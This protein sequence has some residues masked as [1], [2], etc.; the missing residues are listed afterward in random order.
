MNTE[1]AEPPTPTRKLWARILASKFLVVSIAVHLLFGV[2]ATLYVVQRYSA[3]RKLTFQGGP[4]TT[5]P[6]KRALEHKVSMAKKKNSM[7]APAQAKRITTSGLAKI[8]LPEMPAMP[9]ATTVTANRMGG[10]G[11]FG[12]GVGPPGGMGR[13]GGGGVGGGGL[14]MF[15][16]R[17][18]GAGLVGTFYDLKQTQDGK[19]TDVAPVPGENVDVG[20]PQAK[21]YVEIV[22]RFVT[23]GWNVGSLGKYFKAPNK[24]VATQFMLPNMSALEAPK[25]FQVEKEVQARRWLVHYEGS[26][27]PP[28]AGR[29]RFIGCADDIMVVRCKG[30]NVLD[31]CIDFYRVDPKI[32]GEDNV[33]PGIIGPTPMRASHWIEMREGESVKMEVL[34]GENPGG[35]FSGALMVERDGDAH[36]PGVFPVFQLK[37]M[38]IPPGRLPRTEGSI[39]FTA[40]APGTGSALDAL[41][42]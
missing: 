19:P 2:G 5:N 33:G 15:G 10:M 42:H 25:A 34:I 14:T 30:R 38:D 4:P 39:I 18:Q 6:S 29:Y 1:S 17:G 37:K 9:T 7:S 8:V 3:Q 21:K 31:A 20:S 41:R 23:N 22:K 11:G 28:N 24:L 27:T 40:A 35:E 32:N 26:I 16:F 36:P 13:G 12:S